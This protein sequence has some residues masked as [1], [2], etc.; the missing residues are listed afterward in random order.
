MFFGDP[1]EMLS[2]AG[3]VQILSVE[4]ILGA[5]PKILSTTGTDK[6]KTKKGNTKPAH[7]H[8]EGTVRKPSP[9]PNRRRKEKAVPSGGGKPI[10]LRHTYLVS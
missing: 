1:E 2:G 10:K 3:D 8:A 9:S 5:E 7:A 4:D 6:S